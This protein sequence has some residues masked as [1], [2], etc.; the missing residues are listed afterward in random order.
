MQ[1]CTSCQT[2]K[3]IEDFAWKNKSTGKRQTKC[4]QC[5]SK[6]VANHY[7]TNKRAYIDRAVSSRP[8]YYQRNRD[9]LNTYKSNL[10]CVE[11]GENHPATLDFHHIDPSGKDF[12][13]ANFGGKS[14]TKIKDEIE[15]CIVLCANCHRK[16][17]WN[18]KALVT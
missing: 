3:P 1:Y 7:Q 9:F 14:I 16:L 13:V 12:G 15:K 8:E 11:C 18:E 2:T 6:Y 4:K 17:H 5:H 10:K